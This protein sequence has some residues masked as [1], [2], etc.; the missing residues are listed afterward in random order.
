MAIAVAF[1]PWFPELSNNPKVA[2]GFVAGG[3]SGGTPF[4]GLTEGF[5]G[6]D[7]I[8]TIATAIKDA[9][10]AE[11]TAIRDALWKTRLEGVTDNIFFEKQGP[12]GME[13]GQAPASVF[14]VHIKDGKIV[15]E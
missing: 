7:G 15:K 1:A 8:K 9:G 3:K 10:K 13:S 4:Q 11:P 5:R 2:E 14:I 6:Y 12:K